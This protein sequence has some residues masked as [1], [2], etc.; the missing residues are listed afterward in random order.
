MNKSDAVES[1]NVHVSGTWNESD[2]MMM[3]KV[4]T[5]CLNLRINTKSK[6]HDAKSMLWLMNKE[7]VKPLVLVFGTEQVQL[8][9][10]QQSSN[11][12]VKFKPV[13]W[14]KDA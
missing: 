6:P 3:D 5:D 1:C 9:K 13:F 8:V 4:D 14:F 2:M 12:G 10:V 11:S 7:K